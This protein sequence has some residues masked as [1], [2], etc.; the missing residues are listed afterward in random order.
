MIRVV[1]AM[2]TKKH[3]S[4][5]HNLTKYDVIFDKEY[6]I[7]TISFE[8]V[9][10]ASL[11][12]YNFIDEWMNGVVDKNLSIINKIMKEYVEHKRII[13]MKKKMKRKRVIKKIQRKLAGKIEK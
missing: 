10:K 12:S 2:N 4:F 13:K 5:L 9:E 6:Y 11:G 1:L 8:T 7:I 3:S